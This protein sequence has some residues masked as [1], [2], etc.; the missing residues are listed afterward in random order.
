MQY[1]YRL[2]EN[3]Y[4]VLMYSVAQGHHYTGL[5][6]SPVESVQ[7]LNHEPEVVVYTT[8][9][10]PKCLAIQGHPE[11]MNPDALIIEKL[12]EILETL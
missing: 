2:P 8:P 5:E 7:L 3:C 12:N 11:M 9:N 4:K 1:P 10:K 6:L